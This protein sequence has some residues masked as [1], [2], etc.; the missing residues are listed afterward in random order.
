MNSPRWAHC[1]VQ[2]DDALDRFLTDYLGGK[3][4]RL[5]LLAGAG[6][7]PRSIALSEKLAALPLTTITALWLR[8]RRPVSTASLHGKAETHKTRLVELFPQSTVA[9][10]PIFATDG[11][12]IGGRE[13]VRLLQKIDLSPYTDVLVDVSALSTGMLFTAV[14]FLYE[15]L[16]GDPNR[17]LHLFVK[18]D[19]TLDFRIR[20]T[21]SDT[22][23]FVHGFRSTFT[24]ESSA[25]AAKL[26]LPQLVPRR[27]MMLEG[28]QTYLAADDICPI[29]PFPNGDPRLGETLVEEYRETLASWNV[30]LRNLLY[31]ADHD[32]RDLYLKITQLHRSRSSLFDPGNAMLVLSPTGGKVIA[33]G[34]L[35]AALDLELPVVLYESVGYELDP[36]PAP[37]PSSTHNNFLMHIW[38]HG[39]AYPPPKYPLE[40]A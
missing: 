36:V 15:Q 31:A 24:L 32:P 21:P 30:D 1:V 2:K 16:R 9:D 33:L 37:L 27:R 28:L 25:R 26:W 38:L 22:P 11:A 17:N 39:A 35:L 18:K 7:D 6:F 3:D 20:G 4:R 19:D 40:V 34:A 14:K 23:V 29:L 8:E 5:F 12:A 13:V 10:V